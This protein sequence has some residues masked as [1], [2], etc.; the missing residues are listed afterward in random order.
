MAYTPL[1]NLHFPIQYIE[2]CDNL[3]RAKGGDLALFHKQCGL[4]TSDL[5]DPLLMIHGEQL[6]RAYSLVQEYCTD[7]RPASLQVLE[8]FPLTSHGMLGMLALAARSIGEALQAAL[9][10]FPLMMPAFKVHKSIQNEHVYLSFERVCDF[11]EQNRFFTELVMMVLYKIEPFTLHPLKNIM[12]EFEHPISDSYQAFIKEINAE[13]IIHDSSNRNV[14]YFPQENLDIPLITQSPTM[15]Q[16]LQDNLR[17]RMQMSQQLKPVSMQVKRLIE[18]LLDE[19]RLINAEVIANH[20]HLSSR[21][22][23]RRL[24]NEGNNLAQLHREVAVE[25]A[26]WLLIN[27][28]KTIAQVAQKSGFSNESNFSRAFKGVMGYTPR[29]HREKQNKI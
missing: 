29:E 12:I 27:S 17:Q 21:T 6:L 22:L 10:F 7:D 3:I 4:N 2:V 16:L 11:G 14:L 18:L 9:E 13:F 28:T 25:Y 1:S 5:L 23:T 19:N 15:F 24:A 26:G 20:L 8:H